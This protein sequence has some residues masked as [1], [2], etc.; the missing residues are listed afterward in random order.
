MVKGLEQASQSHE[1]YCHDLVVMSSNP[2]RVELC[3]ASLHR[4]VDWREIFMKQPV[5]KCKQIN[6]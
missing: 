5:G 3:N 6:F 2:S 1:M 4:F